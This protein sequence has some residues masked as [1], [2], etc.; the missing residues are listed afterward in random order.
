MNYDA[1][2]KQFLEQRYI[3][4]WTGSCYGISIG[5]RRYLVYTARGLETR[6]DIE[7]SFSLKN[8]GSFGNVHM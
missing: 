8:V 2:Q 1:T 3:L 6:S 7:F 4:G 5:P